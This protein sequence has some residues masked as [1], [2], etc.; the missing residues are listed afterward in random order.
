[1]PI[2]FRSCCDIPSKIFTG[3]IAHA[4][5]AIDKKSKQ[6]PLFGQG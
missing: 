4:F 3:L 2:C 5:E 6:E 1:M